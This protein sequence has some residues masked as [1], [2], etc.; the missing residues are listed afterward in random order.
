MIARPDGGFGRTSE[1]KFEKLGG[2]PTRRQQNEKEKPKHSITEE[3][4]CSRREDQFSRADS[5]RGDDCAGSKDRQPSERIPGSK[6]RRKVAF[7]GRFLRVHVRN[8]HD[9]ESAFSTFWLAPSKWTQ[10]QTPL[11]RLR[12]SLFFVGK[13]LTSRSVAKKFCFRVG[14]STRNVN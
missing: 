9:N 8:C 12:P 7:I 4:T 3:R 11:F 14:L 5:E 1:G 13:R 6:R 2:K 10:P